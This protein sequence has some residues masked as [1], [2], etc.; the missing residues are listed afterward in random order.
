MNWEDKRAGTKWNAQDCYCKVYFQQGCKGENKQLL[1]H[2]K[3][4]WII[5]VPASL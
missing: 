3:H 1:M 5:D 4:F 2:I